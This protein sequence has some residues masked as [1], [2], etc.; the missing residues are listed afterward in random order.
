[1]RKSYLCSLQ[2]YINL[3]TIPNNNMPNRINTSLVMFLIKKVCFRVAML[4]KLHTKI[5]HQTKTTSRLNQR[6]KLREIIKTS[7]NFDTIEMGCVPR[8]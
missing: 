3:A 8:D 4:E 1:M 6:G 5:C 2:K 7:G